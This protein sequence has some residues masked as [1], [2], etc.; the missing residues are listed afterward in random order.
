MTAANG[1]D[2]RSFRT[3]P[4]ST[5]FINHFFT[6]SQEW[7]HQR[8]VELQDTNRDQGQTNPTKNQRPHRTG[9]E[10]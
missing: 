5:Q 3:P 7:A 8:T 2:V 9:E 4:V 6:R 10:P 1:N